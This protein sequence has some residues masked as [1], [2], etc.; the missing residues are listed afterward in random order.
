MN[1]EKVVI[2]GFPIL[3]CVVIFLSLFTIK[4]G[5]PVT[6]FTIGI[7]SGFALGFFTKL[8][9]DDFYKLDSLKGFRKGDNN[10]IKSFDDIIKV[11][12]YFLYIWF[13]PLFTYVGCSLKFLL[14]IGGL[15][16]IIYLIIHFISKG[17]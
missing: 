2:W 16:L 13:A 9:Y 11:P 14:I 3:L 10:F 4:Y 15:M 12:Y 1:K 7:I 17:L 8:I 6:G 5:R